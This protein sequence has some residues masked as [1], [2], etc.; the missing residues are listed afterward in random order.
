MNVTFAYDP[1]REVGPLQ[2]GLGSSFEQTPT[3]FAEEV[4]AAEI[5]F[6]SEEQVAAFVL[7]KIKRE[8]IDTMALVTDFTKDWKP[9]EPEAT[10]RFKR[11]FQTD[12]DPGEVTA[13]LTLST[14]CPYSLKGRYYFVSM[15]WKGHKAAINTS[16]H[17]LIHFYTHELIEPMFIEA[18]IQ[19]RFGDFKEALSV[20][21]NLEC[22]DLLDGKDQGYHKHQELRQEITEQWQDKN[23]VYAIAKE[24]IKSTAK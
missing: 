15:A 8:G 13:Y 14:R 19:P 23:D 16:L 1:S 20:L 11:I 12:W 17:E 5:D 22:A 3:S 10:T 9:I 2:Y 7:A 24:Y 18:N 6:A 4:Q 21:L